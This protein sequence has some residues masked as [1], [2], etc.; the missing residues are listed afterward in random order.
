MIQSK[1]LDAHLRRG[2]HPAMLIV[3][4]Y[5]WIVFIL[6]TTANAL[7]WPKRGREVIAEHPERAEGYAR[8]SRGLLFWGNLPWIVMG[9]GCLTGD[10]IVFDFFRPKEG[11][12]F[13]VAF[14]VTI[15]LEW[16]LCLRWLFFLGGAEALVAHPGLL[17]Y[18]FKSPAAIK[19]LFAVC[20][21]GGIVGL[22]VLFTTPMPDLRK[23]MAPQPTTEEASHSD[24]PSAEKRP[25]RP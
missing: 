6:T 21:A 7:T 16:I 1:R 24:A 8:L 3:L 25:A 19:G 2:Y 10:M 5:F 22:I 4:H 20:L 14:F 13:V 18:P 23:T 9:L 15:I 11:N 17:N 12:P